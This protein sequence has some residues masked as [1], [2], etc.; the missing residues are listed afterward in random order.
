MY[1][2]AAIVKKRLALARKEIVR[3]QNNT[4]V[5]TVIVNVWLIVLKMENSVYF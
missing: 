5:H 3:C 1:V 4:R 2:K